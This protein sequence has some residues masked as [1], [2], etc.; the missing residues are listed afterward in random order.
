L[1]FT[2]CFSAIPSLESKVL[3]LTALLWSL[4]CVT[5]ALRTAL[6]TSTLRAIAVGLITLMIAGPI[7]AAI[8]LRVLPVRIL[9]E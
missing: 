8:V 1:V 7:M 3:A 6:S 4:V 2:I 9:L 5:I